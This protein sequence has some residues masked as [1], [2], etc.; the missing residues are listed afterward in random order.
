[1]MRIRTRGFTLV[2]LLVVIAIIGVLVALMLPAIQSAR[3]AARRNACAHNVGQLMM[4]VINYESAHEMLPSGVKNP[5]GPIR[6][7]RVGLHQGWLISLLPYIDEGNAYRLVDFK[8]SVY[9]PENAQVAKLSPP[10]FRCPSHPGDVAGQ[11][12]YAGNQNDT[13]API[14]ENNHGLL[15]LNSQLRNVDILDGSTHTL[16]ISEKQCAPDDLG[17]MS[18]TRS[19]LR[20][21][22][23]PLNLTGP[24]EVADGKPP[25][26]ANVII[27]SSDA[28]TQSEQVDG[29][30]E[31][32]AAA[33]ATGTS[34]VASQ[35]IDP[36]T[37]VGGFG[38]WHA[39]GVV[40]SAFGDGSVR[41][42]S[43][44]MDLLV[45]R[46][47]ANRADGQLQQVPE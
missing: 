13:E 45:L 31:P 21:A 16:V 17:W 25:A 5:T 38:S 24:N 18:G 7:E 30:A 46:R 6:N 40:N 1:M 27:L 23:T 37:Y 3:E 44:S 12:C 42:L 34:V 10:V 43:D 47:L 2:E 14:D 39:G 33:L 32:N 26:A 19:T 4:A 28:A 41:S 22:G 36:I 15:F 9:A 11:S 29:E 8:A 20:N 35:P